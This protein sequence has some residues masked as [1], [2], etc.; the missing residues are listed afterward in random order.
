MDPDETH[1]SG[2]VNWGGDHPRLTFEGAQLLGLIGLF[3]VL[4]IMAVGFWKYVQS[5]R[6]PKKKPTP[7]SA[8]V[9]LMDVIATD[10]NSEQ[11][12]QSGD[13]ERL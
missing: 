6:R 4:G 9:N 1:Q 12:R 3:L 10:D 8:R 13:N 2:L 5:Q 7:R 11:R